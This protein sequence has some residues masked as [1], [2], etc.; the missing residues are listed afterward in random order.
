[1]DRP[2][3]GGDARPKRILYVDDNLSNLK[4]V[5][6]IVELGTDFELVTAEQGYEGLQR[7]RSEAFDLVL[8]DLNLPDLRGDEVLVALRS[9]PATAH[10]PTVVVTAEDDASTSAALL[11][12]GAAAFVTKPF[13]VEALVALV[14]ELVARPA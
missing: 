4:L 13:D 12:A 6:A 11:K 8:L 3:P 7:A 9:D 2:Y 5:R 1:M 14:E 10:I